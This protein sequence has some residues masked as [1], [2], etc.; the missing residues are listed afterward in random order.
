MLEL[1]YALIGA[2]LVFES[3][4]VESMVM[5]SILESM[6]LQMVTATAMCQ[7]CQLLEQPES[8]L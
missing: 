2:V 3:I 5:E 4:V 6:V 8:L 1:L 7:L